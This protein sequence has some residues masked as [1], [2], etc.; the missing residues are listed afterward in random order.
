[1]KRRNRRIIF[2]SFAILFL[3][4]APLIVFYSM[5]WRFSWEEKRF[6]RPGMFYCK[7]A[8]RATRVFLDNKKSEKTDVLFGSLLMENISPGNHTF[9]IEKKDYHPWKKTLEIRKG[10]V[11]EAKNIVLIPKNPKFELISKNI[12]NSFF[13]SRGQQ[14]IMV[15]SGEEQWTLK[16][17]EADKNLKSHLIK[18]EDISEKNVD[19]IFL[20]ITPDGKSAF[21]KAAVAGEI[22]YFLL[23]ISPLP[24]SLEQLD[25]S[26]PLN[27][28]F[29]P[30]EPS[31]IFYI[32]ENELSELGQKKSLKG[33]ITAS[34]EGDNIY[35][36]NEEGFVIKTDYA[37]Q[38]QEKISDSPLPIKQETKYSIN[39]TGSYISLMEGGN[40]YLL[41]L[42]E[43]KEFKKISENV[44]RI[45]ISPDNKKI[46]YF[47]ESE[48]WVIFLEDIGDQP[49]R[50]RGQVQFLSRFSEEVKDV[51]WYTSHYLIFNTGDKIKVSEID[52]RDKIN[53]SDLAE[54]KE[55]EIFWYQ[56]IN[57]LCLLSKGNFFCSG[58]LI[59]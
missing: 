32:K 34:L 11:T 53:S 56:G 49:Q 17:V 51:F 44:K 50:K 23:D 55:V 24:A 43:E 54:F 41:D 14:T 58:P 52:N 13:S 26:G 1:M 57:K 22:N 35:F 37:F 8:P 46:A 21:L 19:L 33:V 6:I 31:R 36:L 59:L 2:A 38:S 10:K 27:V 7:T 5:G 15:E 40:F 42:E 29:H 20:K 4:V 39:K 30:K 48:I 28:Y 25:L 45:E 3:V 18:K 47:N 16:L 9:T 12:E